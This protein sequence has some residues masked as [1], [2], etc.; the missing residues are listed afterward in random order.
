MAFIAT[1]SAVGTFIAATLFSLW[2]LKELFTG[3]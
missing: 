2:L 1:V 3:K